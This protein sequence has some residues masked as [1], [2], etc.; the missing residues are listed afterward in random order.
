M[1]EPKITLYPDGKPG[2]VAAWN[3]ELLLNGKKIAGGNV[4][5]GP[6]QNDYPNKPLEQPLAGALMELL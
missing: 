4:F 1:D 3:W 6:R 2:S 5:E